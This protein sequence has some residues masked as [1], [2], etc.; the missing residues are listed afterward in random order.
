MRLAIKVNWV[1][2][3]KIFNDFGFRAYRGKNCG[4]RVGEFRLN[5]IC[6][7]KN[8]K[9]FAMTGNNMNVNFVAFECPVQVAG[10]LRPTRQI[11]APGRESVLTYL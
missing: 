4:D 2:T 1:L 5:E 7:S 3:E 9:A 8:L 6:I 11:I 10:R